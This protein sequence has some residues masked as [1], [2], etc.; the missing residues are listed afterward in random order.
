MTSRLRGLFVGTA[1][2]A[3]LACTGCG[4]KMVTVKG[5][6]LRGGQP[7]VVSEDTYVTLSFVPDEATAIAAGTSSAQSAKFDPRT[8]TYRVDLKPGKYRTMLVV[9]LPQPEGKAEP[10]KGKFAGGP[11]S[12]PKVN[13]PRPVR[14]DK[15]YELTK[16]QDLDIEVP[17]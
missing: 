10:K 3:L 12:P 17:G 5:K 11:K 14:S 4:E 8:G 6:L 9:A 16:D 1:L 2:A 13:A 7:M 15:V